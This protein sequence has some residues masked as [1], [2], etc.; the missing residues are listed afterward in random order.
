MLHFI[1]F[2]LSGY[3]LY[4]VSAAVDKWPQTSYIYIITD[5]FLYNVPSVMS[6]SPRFGVFFLEDRRNRPVF[7][8]NLKYKKEKID[9]IQ[10]LLRS[11]P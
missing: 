9:Y 5:K 3:G 7:E 4:A 10:I 11:V 6:I 2:A 8:T 1:P